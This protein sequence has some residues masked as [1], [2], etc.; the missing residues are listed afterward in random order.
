MGANIT[1]TEAHTL[2]PH[3]SSHTWVICPVGLEDR[4]I[5]QKD[6]AS[7]PGLLT[8]PQHHTTTLSVP[9]LLP[10]SPL[11]DAEEPVT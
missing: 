3:A 11:E 6:K 10:E 4:S 7:R 9:R 2:L 1:L 8:A 5:Y